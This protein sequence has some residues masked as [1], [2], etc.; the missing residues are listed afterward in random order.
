MGSTASFPQGFHVAKSSS[1]SGLAAFAAS[2]LTLGGYL[3]LLAGLAR[4][5]SSSSFSA[6][7]RGRPLFFGTVVDK[8]AEMVPSSG[9]TFRGQ[10]R[11][12]SIIGATSA[13]EAPSSKTFGGRPLPPRAW[14]DSGTSS[15]ASYTIRL[16][17][18][19]APDITGVGMTDGASFRTIL[20]GRP[21]FLEN[22]GRAAGIGL[23][24]PVVVFGGV[25][26]RLGI[27]G[28]RVIGVASS[29]TFCGR[30]RGFGA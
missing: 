24:N 5:G 22:L 26:G 20:E 29:V 6:S 21:R 7:F 15:A 27:F 16:D 30:P 12:R 23:V 1:P 25:P 14:T 17:G 3:R 19:R 11:C 2:V 28:L 18:S 13:G 8:T 4:T 9:T 10:P